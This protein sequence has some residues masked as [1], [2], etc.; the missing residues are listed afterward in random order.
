MYILFAFMRPFRGKKPFIGTTRYASVASHLGH[1]LGRK[2]DME[3]LGYMLVY[4][5]KGILPW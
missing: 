1:E 2:D 4:M 3:S 5:A